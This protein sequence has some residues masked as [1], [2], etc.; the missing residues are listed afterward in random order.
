MNLLINSRNFFFA[1]LLIIPLISCNS[2]SDSILINRPTEESD[3]DDPDNGANDGEKTLPL[4]DFN[5][6]RGETHAHT[7]Y[8]WSH[9]SHR[10]GGNYS[11]LEPDWDPPSGTGTDKYEFPP[12]LEPMGEVNPDF[13]NNYQGPPAYYFAMA[14]ERGLDFYNISDHSQ[15]LPLQPA[16]P[17]NPYW[18]DTQAAAAKYDDD[19]EFVALP[20]SEYSRNTSDDGGRGHLNA[21][22]VAEYVNA[23]HNTTDH[24]AEPWPEADWSIPQFYDWLKDVEPAGGSGYVVASFN[25]PGKT[26]FGDWAH[27]DNE[28]DEIISLFELRTVYRS[29]N[30]DGFVRALN[31]GWKV[32]P[33]SVT[34]SHGYWHIENIPPLVNVLAPKL[35]REAITRAMRQRRT[36]TSWAGERNTEVDL[37]Y[38]VN[39][40]IMGS[41]LEDV[42]SFDFEVE[43]NTHPQDSEQTV[44]K[45][46]ILRNHPDDIDRIEVVKE[47]V[48]DGSETDVVWNTTVDDDTAKYFFLRIYHTSDMENGSYNEHGST[49]SAPVWTGK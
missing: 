16:E 42:S 35:T 6:Y 18:M 20:G 30:F 26:Q 48:F 21:I 17:D 46:Q 3:D 29:F 5:I 27:R 38:S 7:V 1:F 43:I 28:V 47:T 11:E 34:D 45:I 49:Y 13:Y 39:G 8:T 2:S 36:Y 4:S 24:P 22:N 41:V 31:K 25:H 12:V 10:T 37:K 15:E 14:K 23:G 19:P 44:R 9:G 32:S 40:N 33:I